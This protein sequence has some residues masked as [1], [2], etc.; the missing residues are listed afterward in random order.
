MRRNVKYNH[1]MIDEIGSRKYRGL[2]EV[3]KKLMVRAGVVK[4]WSLDPNV[5]GTQ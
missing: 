2:K 1:S 5:T 4:Y 3:T